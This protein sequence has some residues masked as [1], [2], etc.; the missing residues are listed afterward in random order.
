MPAACLL[1]PD[2][3]IVFLLWFLPQSTHVFC[4]NPSFSTLLLPSRDVSQLASEIPVIAALLVVHLQAVDLDAVLIAP[5]HG[6]P[7]DLN[8]GNGCILYAVC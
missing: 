1:G 4:P 7:T 3:V 2:L 6:G 8:S 5:V